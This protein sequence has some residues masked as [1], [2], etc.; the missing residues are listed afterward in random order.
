MGK[1][2][3]AKNDEDDKDGKDDKVD[4]N[5]MGSDKKTQNLEIDN[6]RLRSIQGIPETCV[7]YMTTSKSEEDVNF[8]VILKSDG[9]C[10]VF[11]LPTASGTTY[12]LASDRQKELDDTFKK[13][14]AAYNN[15][16]NKKFTSKECAA[17]TVAGATTPIFGNPHFVSMIK[18]PGTD[19][20][21]STCDPM[22]L[23]GPQ[24]FN[25]TQCGGY[26]A[27]IETQAVIK[28]ASTKLENATIA[29]SSIK[30]FFTEIAFKIATWF[31]GARNKIKL[32]DKGGRINYTGPGTTYGA[33]ADFNA[34]EFAINFE[35]RAFIDARTNNSSPGTTLSKSAV[36]NL[37]DTQKGEDDSDSHGYRH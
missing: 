24:R 23:L 13:C 15:A 31:A 2:G 17:T 10:P 8:C 9:T 27:M 12:M 14:L 35:K 16:T 33:M 26:S 20:N 22:G 5:N 6:L 21:W 4:L 1:L 11:M 32:D 30:Q 36:K 29:P 19:N 18:P 25:T 34:Q 28:Y 7:S 37:E 3:H